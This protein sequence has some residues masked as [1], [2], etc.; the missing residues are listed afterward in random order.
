MRKESLAPI[1]SNLIELGDA[2]GK[3]ILEVTLEVSIFP[4]ELSH[5]SNLNLSGKRCLN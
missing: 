5:P 3:E 2:P 4:A 1:R